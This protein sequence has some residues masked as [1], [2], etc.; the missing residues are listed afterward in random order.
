MS[1]REKKLSRIAL[2]EYALLQ[3]EPDMCLDSQMSNFTPTH[4][5]HFL[6][7]YAAVCPHNRHKIRSQ[8]KAYCKIRDTEDDE[9][10]SMHSYYKALAQF[11]VLCPGV[12]IPDSA[13]KELSHLGDYVAQFYINNITTKTAQWNYD[14]LT[15]P[16]SENLI[17]VTLTDPDAQKLGDKFQ[18]NLII[19]LN[20][21]V[22]PISVVKQLCGSSVAETYRAQLETFE[23]CEWFDTESARERGQ[24][25]NW[26]TVQCEYKLR[27]L[28]IL[29]DSVSE[30]QSCGCSVEDTA[31]QKFSKR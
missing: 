19:P 5:R 12:Q 16:A 27:L 11:Y 21:G 4:K 2:F 14:V 28:G 8:F 31:M 13:W 25:R 1:T 18:R 30:A 17:G 6:L 15:G 29:H 10:N 7:Q 24:K 9:G 22:P 3:H 20:R 23:S 26:N